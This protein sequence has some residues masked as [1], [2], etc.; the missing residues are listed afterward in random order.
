MRCVSHVHTLSGWSVIF[1]VQLV[2]AAR[3]ARP[4]SSWPTPGLDHLCC[5]LFFSVCSKCSGHAQPFFGSWSAGKK[6]IVMSKFLVSRI[7]VTAAKRCQC[8]SL[9]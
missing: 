2:A 8:Y 9:F 5:G 6:R 3:E 7:T 1:S 4:P